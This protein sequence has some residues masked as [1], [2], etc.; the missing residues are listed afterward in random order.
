MQ[1]NGSYN[2]RRTLQNRFATD[3]WSITDDAPIDRRLFADRSQIMPK[4]KPV[5]DWKK[6]MKMRPF[7]DL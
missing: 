2:D 7:K 3:V 6:Q 1:P 4:I 5:A